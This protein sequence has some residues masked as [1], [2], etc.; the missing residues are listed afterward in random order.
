MRAEEA[1]AQYP[2]SPCV[3]ICRLGDDGH[4]E[5]CLRT[6]DEI[7]RWGEMAAD[8]RLAVFRS[9]EEREESTIY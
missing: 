1:L 2:D 9:L 5:G 3:G 6:L 4:C 8:E 7:A